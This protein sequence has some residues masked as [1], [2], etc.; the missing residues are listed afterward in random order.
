MALTSSLKFSDNIWISSSAGLHKANKQPAPYLIHG[1]KII[2]GA[3]R[4]W[5][6]KQVWT[7]QDI[8]YVQS[9]LSV[10]SDRKVM[11]LV[12]F[13]QALLEHEDELPENMKPSQL[14]KDLAREIRLSEVCLFSLG[15]NII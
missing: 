3:F 6:K 10:Y 1:A 4:A 13:L 8:Q 14:I 15:I 11:S 7:H 5:T 2:N 9:Q 12:C